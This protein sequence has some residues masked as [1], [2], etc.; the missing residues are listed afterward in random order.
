[1]SKHDYSQN[2]VAG[3]AEE[4]S[5]NRSI[6]ADSVLSTENMQYSWASGI[7]NNVVTWFEVKQ[8]NRMKAEL[9][10]IL[11]RADSK[12]ENVSGIIETT[13]YTASVS[14]EKSINLLNGIID[15]ISNLEVMIS[16][17]D[18]CKIS[19]PENK[20]NTYVANQ[21]IKLPTDQNVKKNIPNN[22]INNYRKKGLELEKYKFTLNNSNELEMPASLYML[23]SYMF[24]NNEF[25]NMDEEKIKKIINDN[26]IEVN[27]G[28]IDIV[29]SPEIKVY[30]EF[31]N[32]VS[33]NIPKEFIELQKQI[34]TIDM[35]SVILN[36]EFKMSE[37]G[38]M[39]CTSSK[40]INNNTSVEV[41]VSLDLKT[42]ETKC[43]YT[44]KTTDS[45]GKTSNSISY[46]I[47][48]D[49]VKAVAKIPLFQS[50]DSLEKVPITRE[51]V[52]QKAIQEGE[53]L[54]ILSFI[55]YMLFSA[56][57]AA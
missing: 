7:V 55:L 20:N 6:V 41:E 18:N 33:A 5:K 8:I 57:A 9:E 39:K 17:Y 19:K 56:L 30:I 45:E 25:L 1:M 22:N 23:S 38:V 4:I 15:K 44:L 3:I 34:K 47:K 50:A 42:G 51:N 2:T 27:S 46:V 35:S 53:Y 54:A 40:K 10:F 31:E 11:T 37:D 49:P 21:N 43:K 26:E 28:R 32:N 48:Y 14:L 24:C 13:D 12:L 29:N 36:G 52:W 16:E